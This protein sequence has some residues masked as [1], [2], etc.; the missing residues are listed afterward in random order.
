M[1]AAF[2]LT[3]FVRNF[4]VL[5]TIYLADLLLPLEK[6]IKYEDAVVTN[7]DGFSPVAAANS[8]LVDL[9]PVRPLLQ[10]NLVDRVCDHLARA[11]A[12]RLRD[13]F[14]RL[15]VVRPKQHGKR[16]PGGGAADRRE[17]GYLYRWQRLVHRSGG[18]CHRHSGRLNRTGFAGGSNS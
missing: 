6:D 10:R 8:D 14:G 9:P 5:L 13:H 1:L 18:G 11:D 17:G 4:K 15:G 2:Y 12:V 7:T 16:R 3:F